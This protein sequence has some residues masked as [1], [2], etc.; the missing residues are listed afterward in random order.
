MMSQKRFQ[1]THSTVGLSL[2]E[3]SRHRWLSIL[4]GAIIYVVSGPTTGEEDQTIHVR[5]EGRQ[6]LMF[7]IDLTAGGIEISDEIEHRM[8]AS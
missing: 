4:A 7:A 5:W 3:A 6:L 8:A 1:L 2:D